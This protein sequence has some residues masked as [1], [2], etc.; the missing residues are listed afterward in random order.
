[1]DSGAPRQITGTAR[2]A[3]HSKQP[4]RARVRAADREAVADGWDGDGDPITVCA[5]SVSFEVPRL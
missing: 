1:M 2:D 5:R 3:G 4:N